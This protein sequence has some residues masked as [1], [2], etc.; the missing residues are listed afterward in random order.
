MLY[1]SL[2][3]IKRSWILVLVLLLGAL[4]A[5]TNHSTY[6]APAM[7]PTPDVHTV[8]NP[9]LLITPTNTPFPIPT[10]DD[11]ESSPA[12]GEEPAAPSQPTDNDSVNSN[13]DINT[14]GD[15][16]N[17]NPNDNAPGVDTTTGA[18]GGAGATAT[19][20]TGT[21]ATNTQPGA[22]QSNPTGLN[23]VINVVTLNLRKGP[24]TTTHI[25]DTLF[26]NDQIEVRGRDS[27]GKWLY[28]CCGS[29]SK[30]AGWVSAQFITPKFPAGQTTATLPLVGATAST[31]A[32]IVTT[33]VTSTIT[34]TTTQVAAV[35]PAQV[36]N[37]NGAT[38]IVLEMRP[39]PAFAWQGQTMELY[40]VVH[41]NGDQPIANVRLLDDLPEELALVNATIGAQGTIT[42]TGT[43]QNGPI[44]AINWPTVGANEQLTATI[45]V[46]IEADTPDGA[47]IDNLAVIN[48]NQGNQAVAGITISMPPTL[49]PQFR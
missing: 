14:N 20:T 45:T 48:T 22:T 40:F 9:A 13:P 28:I 49:L 34:T 19:G 33:N 26:M 39:M 6:G 32:P 23:G 25:I 8:P 46:R 44:L 3:L 42:H 38:P 17:N 24:S 12:A 30:G 4:S 16:E 37:N 41:N 1:A 31:A 27:T 15:E 21:S 47:M 7:Q 36:I 35:K 5:Y 29:R 18:T 11:E 10:P 43:T 2:N